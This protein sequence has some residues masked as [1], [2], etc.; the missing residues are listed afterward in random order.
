MDILLQQLING[1]TLG[2]VYALVALGYTMV[3]GII[4]LINFAHGE[5]VMVGA[6]TALSVIA[7]LLKLGLGLPPA[8]IVLAA[9]LA[10]VA[11]CMAL[12]FIMERVAYRPLRGAPRLAPLITAI[13]VSIILQNT[14]MMLWGGGYFSSPPLMK[15]TTYE[16]AGAVVTDMQVV[17]VLAAAGLMAA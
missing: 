13:G 15:V 7:A 17:I 9:L 12:A 11:L 8:L 5:L 6:L 10:A 3:Y 14:A 16:I 2:S 4:G 1:V